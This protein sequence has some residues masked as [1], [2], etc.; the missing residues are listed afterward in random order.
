MNLW[1]GKNFPL[2]LTLVRYKVLVSNYYVL[3]LI[4]RRMLDGPRRDVRRAHRPTPAPQHTDTP[5]TARAP[6]RPE[7]DVTRRRVPCV[8]SFVLRLDSRRA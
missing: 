7:G 5:L 1:Y 6:R 4:E 2:D 8:V 3:K